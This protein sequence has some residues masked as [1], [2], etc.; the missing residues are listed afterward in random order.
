MRPE[1]L[2][3]LIFASI[4]RAVWRDIGGVALGFRLMMKLAR[5]FVSPTT[6]TPSFCAGRSASAGWLHRCAA[7][8]SRRDKGKGK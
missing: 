5:P 2:P 7:P 4:G 8:A 6:P 3:D 1:Q